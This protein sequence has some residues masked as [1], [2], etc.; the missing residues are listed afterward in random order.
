MLAVILIVGLL[1]GLAAVRAV[2]R[3][4]LLNA[5]REE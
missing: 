1:S 5:L 2:L 4:P 3:A